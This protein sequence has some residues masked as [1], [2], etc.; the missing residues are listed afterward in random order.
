[1]KK[2]LLLLAFAASPAFA[3]SGPFFSLR[4]T[5]FVV[6]L[7]F[8]V[9]IGA[10]IY[11]KVPGI[12]LGMLDKRAANIRAELEEARALRDEA[13]SILAGYERKSRDVQEQAD[14]I[15]TAAKRDAVAAA[16]QVK[17]ELKVSIARRLKAA[18]EQIASAE[19]A[20]LRD[21]KDRAVSVAVAAAA[22]V[23]ARQMSASDKAGLIDTA[24]G[25]VETRLH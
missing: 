2:L 9:F 23:L 13:Q 11:F 17:A 21:V 18:E 10:L 14:Q 6:T 20:A 24:I 15:V 22:E 25:E 5:D 3:A 7:G 8:L 19:A 1:M 4:N 12:L 16:E